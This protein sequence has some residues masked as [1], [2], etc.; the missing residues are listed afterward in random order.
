[1]SIGE[2]YTEEIFYYWLDRLNL[3]LTIKRYPK[4]GKYA[5]RV[6]HAWEHHPVL[7][8]TA[9]S[10]E[11]LLKVLVSRIKHIIDNEQRYIKLNEKRR[12]LFDRHD[13]Q[14]RIEEKR[15]LSDWDNWE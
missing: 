11:N 3:N 9:D 8:D 4:D 10:Y 5:G 6:W 13:K 2:N 15:M 14:A 12:A 7:S 1:M